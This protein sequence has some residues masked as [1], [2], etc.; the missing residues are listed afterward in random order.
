MPDPKPSQSQAGQ[1]VYSPAARHFHWWTAALL[2]VQVPVGVMMAYRGN[3]LNIWDGLT[4][5]LYS[6]HKLTGLVIL[7]VVVARL[8]YRLSHGSPADEP[9]LEP[10]QKVVSHMTH[11]AIYALLVI[12]ALLGWL[13]VSYFPAL[14]AFG[15]KIPALFVSPDEAKSTTVLLAHRAAAFL[16]VALI[17]MHVAA[18]LFHY[19]IRKDGVLNRM[20]PGL[21]RRDGK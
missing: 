7:A 14:D 16:L 13:G 18:A 11:W 6:T 1:D 17:G 2:A 8:G 12:L 19:V 3:T 10:W 15:L 20:L 21:P 5:N 4:N 9:T